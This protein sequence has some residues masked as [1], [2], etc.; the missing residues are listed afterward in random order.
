MGSRVDQWPSAHVRAVR[1]HATARLHL[2]FL[3]LSGSLGRRFGSLGVS[4]ENPALDLEISNS[5]G[6]SVSGPEPERLAAAVR[7]AASYL[8][9]PDHVAVKLREA[10]PSHA[11][12]GSGTQLSLS[13]AAGLARLFGRA[14]HVESAAGALDRGNRSGV[15]LAAFGSGGFIV[16][17]G[18][19]TT[20][21]PPPIL[22]RHDFPPAWRFLLI[23]DDRL[24]GVHGNAETSAF[25]ALPPFPEELAQRLCRLALMQ[26]LPA[27]VL[28]DFQ[29]FSRGI[30]EIQRV[31]GGFFAPFQGGGHYTSPAVGRAIA[32]LEAVG[33]EGVGQSSWGPTGFAIFPSSEEAEHA[34]SR[35]RVAH[36]D[37][38][39]LVVGARNRGAE[40]FEKEGLETP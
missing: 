40:L 16:D 18:R 27:L 3:D 35:L 33:V 15:G 9:T 36:P 24:Q 17:G 37:L 11:G 1:V 28:A 30:G 34:S 39:F 32:D 6:L 8:G 10:V 21:R 29:P 13:V 2:G 22:A 12:F 26:V 7:A 20:D 19:D 38:R 5:L 14:F 25:R 23:L 31:V 4:L